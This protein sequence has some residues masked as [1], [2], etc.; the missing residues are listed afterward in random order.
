MKTNFSKQTDPNQAVRDELSRIMAS[1]RFIFGSMGIFIG[2]SLSFGI[3]IYLIGSGI[4][5]GLLL[6]GLAFDPPYQLLR[7]ILHFGNLPSHLSPVSLW[8]KIFTCAAMLMPALL[9]IIG[10]RG[11]QV[12]GFCMQSLICLLAGLLNR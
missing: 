9:I 1:N 4:W 10:I 3:L 8:H 5:L 11:L 12:G 6:L 7:K 2:I